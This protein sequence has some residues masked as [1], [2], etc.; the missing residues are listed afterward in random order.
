MEI[1]TYTFFLLALLLGVGGLSITAH[2][3]AIKKIDT[4]TAAD[5]IVLYGIYLAMLLGRGPTWTHALLFLIVTITALW[6]VEYLDKM[7]AKKQ[8]SA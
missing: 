6:Y 4:R 7:A 5:D 1:L 3:A 8:S 2:L